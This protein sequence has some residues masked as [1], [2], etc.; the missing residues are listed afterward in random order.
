SVDR[1]RARQRIRELPAPAGSA[2]WPDAVRLAHALLGKS[3]KA[4]REIV[5]LGDNQKFGWADGDSV[6]RWEL[7]AGE[8]GLSKEGSTARPRLWAVNVAGDRPARLPNWGLGPLRSNRPVVPVEREITFRSDIV[9][10][11]QKTYSPPY[12]LR[13]EVDGKAVR[14]L[15]P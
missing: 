13:L 9:L 6:F 2:S 3:Q 7:L 12:R 11:G 4:Q 5:L 8:L 15:P 14:D 10:Y 1:E